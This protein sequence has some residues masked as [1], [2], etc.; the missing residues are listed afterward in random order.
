MRTRV[1]SP[2]QNGVRER[3]FGSLKYER[4]YREPID[5]PLDLVREAEAF[6]IEF[7][8]IRPHEALAWNRPREVH[9]GLTDPTNPNF[10]EPE[11]LPLP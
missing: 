9:L 7:N 10:P 6:R 11:F 3:A 4:L 2:G 5:D 1:K 8:T